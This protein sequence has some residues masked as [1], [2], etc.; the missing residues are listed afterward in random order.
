[1]VLFL[2]QNIVNIHAELSE[3]RE[4]CRGSSKEKTIQIQTEKKTGRAQNRQ[5]QSPSVSALRRVYYAAP[6]LS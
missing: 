3:Y 2:Y 5:P 6:S 4:L 1:M